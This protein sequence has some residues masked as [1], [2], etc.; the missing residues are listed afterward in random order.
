M[1]EAPVVR[2][3]LLPHAYSVSEQKSADRLAENPAPELRLGPGGALIVISL[4]SLGIWAGI[5]V[6]TFLGSA[7]LG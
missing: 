5:W 4:L 3:G 6:A 7:V 1:M 2:T